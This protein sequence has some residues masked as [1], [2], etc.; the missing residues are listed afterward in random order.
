MRR[1]GIGRTAIVGTGLGRT[2]TGLA[3]TA[4]GTGLTAGIALERY[5][6]ARAR[7]QP[8]DRREEDFG[9]LRGGTPTPVTADDGVVLHAEVAGPSQS[10]V[11]VVL[12]HGYVVDRRCWHYQW[13]DLQDTV[14]VICYDQ[15]AHGRS[16]RGARESSTIDQ[17]GRDLERVLDALAPDG[18]VL[19]VGHSM[20]GMS[21]MALADGRPD[22]FGGRVAGVM[23]ISTSTGRVGEGILGLPGLVSRGVRVVLP[24]AVLVAERGAGLIDLGRSRAG[25]LSFLLTRHYA[26]GTAVSP[27]LVAFMERMVAA[28]KVNVMTEFVMTLM[29]HE[30]LDAIERLAGVDV[31][32]L[33]GE[34]DLVTPASHSE[35]IAQRLPTSRLVVVPGGGH[36]LMLERP[37]TVTSEIT[38]AV[39]RVTSAGPRAVR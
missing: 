37:D 8:D 13:H 26:F 10:P 11:T 30:K 7:R 38:S 28:T 34:R 3:V 21:V 5:L 15:R 12:I 36:M 29:E 32:V 39:T 31:T 9:E 18:P 6:V 24:R 20:G 27:T 2:V 33:V 17:L 22:L 35:A 4:V 16:G 1:T 23:L 25:D 19:L 14:R